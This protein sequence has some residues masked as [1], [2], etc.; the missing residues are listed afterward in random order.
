MSRTTTIP[1]I[2]KTTVRGKTKYLLDLRPFFVEGSNGGRKYFDK[3]RDAEAFLNS[4]LIK[5]K[6][7]K[8]V[9][10][11][12]SV[13]IDVLYHNYIFSNY[14]RR[15][16]KLSG[17][18]V[19]ETNRDKERRYINYLQPFVKDISVSDI[20]KR[21][22]I[23]LTQY[24][25]E[26]DSINGDQIS[27]AL[28]Y[29][30]WTD[31]KGFLNYLYD[32]EII[33]Q[34]IA[35][36]IDAG[37]AKPKKKKIIL[38][39]HKNEFEMYLNEIDSEIEKTYFMLLGKNGPRKSEGK[40]IKFKNV[41]YNTGEIEIYT[42]L[43]KK[44]DGDVKTKTE[45]SKRIIRVDKETMMRIKTHMDERKKTG[46]SDSELKEQYVFVDKKGNPFSN[47]TLRRHHK[48]YVAKAN[49]KYYPIHYLRHFYG[50]QAVMN[51]VPVPVVQ[52]Q[53]GHSRGDTT[54]LKY[55]VEYAEREKAY[56][57]VQNENTNYEHDIQNG[58]KNGNK[59]E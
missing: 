38:C 49:I 40:G 25:E 8:E 22:L 37:I 23:D 33:S 57:G 46:I 39:W 48:E 21:M 58:D 43:K 17:T 5:G 50:T 59:N 45:Y 29:R 7:S 4:L 18:N 2:V 31:F 16:H 47:E 26:L 36:P 30:L 35:I 51:G 13:K 3:R 41:N 6:L 27:E 14:F 52:D 15:K 54:V 42:Q 44:K 12:N 19:E 55:Y 53:M 34:P 10:N 56:E 24:I 1:N 20:N 11:N 28:Q 9:L 32:Y